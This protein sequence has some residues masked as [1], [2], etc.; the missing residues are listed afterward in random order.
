MYWEKR[1]ILF[2]TDKEYLEVF[3]KGEFQIHRDCDRWKN[4]EEDK[5]KVSDDS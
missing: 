4:I 5:K 2:N 1:N 3:K